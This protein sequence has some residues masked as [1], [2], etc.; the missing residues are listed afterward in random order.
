MAITT[1]TGF[2]AA[3]NRA[4][5][6][7]IA[8]T[9]IFTSNATWISLWNTTSFPPQG[10]IPTTPAICTKATLGAVP[11]VYPSSGSLYITEFVASGIGPA[12]GPGTLMAYDRLSHMGGLDATS[13]GVQ[14]VG[15][16]VPANRM[17]LSDLSN[18]GWYVEC[19]V[20]LGSTS[21]TLTI[22]YTNTSNVSGTATIT[23]PA[24]M[25][26]GAMLRIVPTIAGDIIQSIE[27][28]QLG[29]STGA[30]GNFGF[31]NGIVLAIIKATYNVQTRRMGAL[32]V[33]LPTVVD[34]ACI[35]FAGMNGQNTNGVITGSISLGVG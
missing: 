3:A 4:V 28:C 1:V 6:T 25:K 30:V 18:V 9:A 31:T 22:T 33:G 24:T 2:K 12:P 19:Y 16:S 17:A 13:V 15:L 34:N 7:Q 23:I 27:S 21:Q 10:A 32:Q 8:K 11:F 29:G 14:T 35:A 20:Q 26:I 5:T